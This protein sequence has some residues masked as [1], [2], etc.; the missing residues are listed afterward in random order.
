MIP[1]RDHNPSGTAPLVTVGLILVNVL[2]FVVE[3]EQGEN[4]GHF[5]KEYGLT[6]GRVFPTAEPGTSPY[7]YSV[8]VVV[9]FL[10]SMFLHGGWM[11]LIGNMWYLWIFGDNVEDRMGHTKFLIFYLLCGLGAGLVQA[12]VQAELDVPMVGA[13]G[14]IAGVLGAYMVAFPRAR[15]STLVFLGFVAT[16]VELPALF[17]LGF[18]FLLQFVSGMG[19][20]TLAETGGVAWWAHMGGFVLG[21]LLLWVFQKPQPKRR[22]YVYGR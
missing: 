6:P 2:A 21:M 7:E 3:L 12:A 1:F 10:T 11:H 14:A 20:M 22:V 19:S 17:L 15:V 4:L 16:V 5:I 18:W 8:P 9:T 13:S